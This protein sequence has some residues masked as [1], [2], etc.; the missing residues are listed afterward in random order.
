MTTHP[1][2]QVLDDAADAVGV[3]LFRHACAHLGQ[4][5]VAKAGHPLEQDL[6]LRGEVV[7][8]R[9]RRHV[10]GVGHVLNGDLVDGQRGKQA[11]R[12]VDDRVACATDG[13]QGG[14]WVSRSRSAY[15]RR[16]VTK[17]PKKS[18]STP[19][20]TKGQ[21]AVPPV[22][23][24]CRHVGRRVAKTSSTRP[25]GCSRGRA[26][27]TQPSAMLPTR[28]TSWSRPSTTTSRARKSCSAPPSTRCST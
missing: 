13:G 1:R 24:A 9:G 18:V 26:S 10:D 27:S 16:P 4:Q 15:S 25:F 17:P 20:A 5:V 12:T 14:G 2:Q 19:R 7:V 21:P 8:H 22:H 23:R 28:P 6:L 11:H 3:A